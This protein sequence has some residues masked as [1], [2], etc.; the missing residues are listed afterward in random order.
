MDDPMMPLNKDKLLKEVRDVM[1]KFWNSAAREYKTDFPEQ[2]TRAVPADAYLELWTR[3]SHV[4]EGHDC[5]LVDPETVMHIQRRASQES[6][7]RLYRT[8]EWWKS[9]KQGSCPE[10]G[11]WGSGAGCIA[12][13][14]HSMGG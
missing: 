13:G 10:C 4:V 11:G 5:H 8:L 9:G 1:Q 6:R 14:G 7:D 2:T 3:L 12:C